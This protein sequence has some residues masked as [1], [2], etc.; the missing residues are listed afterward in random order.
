ML[1]DVGMTR[2]SQERDSPYWPGH[3]LLDVLICQQKT[4]DGQEAELGDSELVSCFGSSGGTEITQVTVGLLLR[5]WCFPVSD[6][7]SAL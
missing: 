5:L 4:G 3:F 1:C 7:L 2:R 6:G